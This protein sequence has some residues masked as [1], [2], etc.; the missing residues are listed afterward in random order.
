[1]NKEIENVSLCLSSDN[2]MSLINNI[3][4]LLASK[5]S[6]SIFDDAWSADTTFVF[7]LLE[8]SVL[9]CFRSIT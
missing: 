6:F 8:P 1:M 5:L 7:N 9:S 4:L 3:L 2:G